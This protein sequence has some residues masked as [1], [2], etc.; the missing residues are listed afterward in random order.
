MYSVS[1]LSI[2]G[3]WTV[4]FFL[5]EQRLFITF[6]GKSL[7]NYYCNGYIAAMT[8]GYLLN[9]S[10][11][12]SSVEFVLVFSGI[13]HMYVLLLIALN[14]WHLCFSRGILRRKSTGYVLLPNFI[15]SGSIP[16]RFFV[17]A[18]A[19]RLCVCQEIFSPRVLRRTAP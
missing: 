3:Q 15:L 10:S 7:S 4:L 17:L 11:F 1:C 12:R 18:S 5:P 2:N 9:K 13:M 16:N 8:Y 6:K 14:S 19:C